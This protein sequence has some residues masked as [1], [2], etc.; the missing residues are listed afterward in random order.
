MR[1]DR[2]EKEGE[3]ELNK[4]MQFNGYEKTEEDERVR[5]NR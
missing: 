1:D 4:A 2:T 5:V 3:M